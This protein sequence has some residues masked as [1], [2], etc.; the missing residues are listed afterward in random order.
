MIGARYMLPE[1]SEGS[2]FTGLVRYD[3]SIAGNPSAKYIGNLQF[4]PTL[5]INLPGPWFVTFY[6]S[7]DIRINFGDP[8]AGQTGRL[9]L[10]FDVLVGRNVTKDMVV[11][12]EVSAPMVDQYPVYY[13]KTVARLNIRF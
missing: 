12:L 3:F 7:P 2:F 8:V 5:N 4:A 13:F 9:F 1:I 11:S 6:P 10:P